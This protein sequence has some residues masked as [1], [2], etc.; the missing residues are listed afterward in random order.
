[1]QDYKIVPI[2]EQYIESFREAVGSV[3]REHKYLAF[4]D[5]PSSEMVRAYVIENLKENWPHFVAIS[6]GKVVGWCDIASLHRPVFVHSGSLGIGVLE[7]YRGQGIGEALMRAAIAKAQDRGLQRIE[8]T[9][10]E[11]NKPAIALYEKM[12][13]Q[14]EGLHRNAVRIGGE[15]ENHISMALLFDHKDTKLPCQHNIDLT[16]IKLHPVSFKEYPIIQNM[17]RFYVYDM[18]EYMGR[19]DG[20]EIPEDGL[21]ECTDFKKYWEVENT[22]PFL[23]RYKNQIAGFVIIDKKGSDSEV[24]F[25]MAQFF[26]LRAFKGKGVGRY[27]AEQCFNKFRGTWEVM[28]IPGN[29]G[30]YRFWLATIKNYTNSNFTEYMRDI[31]HFNNSRKKIFK[32]DSRIVL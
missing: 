1:M 23:I 25:N 16:E 12:G 21:Y 28:T 8:L 30:A 3:A 20:W 14:V 5:A 2:T 22:F 17:G 9:V 31:A 7:Q 15:Y 27:V 4:L 11:H 32:F 24:D 6:E 18:S 29:E 26:I 10:R 19:E 13:F